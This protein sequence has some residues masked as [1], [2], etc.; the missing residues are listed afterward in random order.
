L[1]KL[2]YDEIY[3]L[4]RS[5]TMLSWVAT[6]DTVKEAIV[7]HAM[8]SV[9]RSKLKNMVG[10]TIDV[11]KPDP[12]GDKKL[13]DED[14]APDP[15][16]HI[17]QGI[18]QQ[19]LEIVCEHY[20]DNVLLP[21]QD[22]GITDK[23][24]D[25]AMLEEEIHQRTGIAI[26]IKQKIF[27]CPELELPS[28]YAKRKTESRSQTISVDGLNLTLLGCDC[29]AVDV[30]HD[31]FKTGQP[32]RL[33][34]FIKAEL[35]TTEG[36]SLWLRPSQQDSNDSELVIDVEAAICP[37][38]QEGRRI[39][40]MPDSSGLMPSRKYVVL[41]FGDQHRRIPIC[42]DEEQA[43]KVIYRHRDELDRQVKWL[44]LPLPR[45]GDWWASNS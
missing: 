34:L 39:F 31:D 15:F 27:S 5:K 8:K 10:K 9:S 4:M 20:P 16:A 26:R 24:L 11:R 23:R 42:F 6:I 21:E 41:R 32:I 29:F 44:G 36:W 28:V 13:K 30:L 2:G 45:P 18:E 33:L 19:M 22:G 14:K 35:D 7:D 37:G 17:M 3:R 40:W 12:V 43:K 25:V 38:L 1:K